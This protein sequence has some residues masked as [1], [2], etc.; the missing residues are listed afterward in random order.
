MFDTDIDT[1]IA[2]AADQHHATEIVHQLRA[3]GFADAQFISHRGGSPHGV[4]IAVQVRDSAERTC[5]TGL[6]RDVGGDVEDRLTA[7][8]RRSLAMTCAG[9]VP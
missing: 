3:V 8:T 6:V 5:A 2:I 1:V 4:R 9:M 7:T